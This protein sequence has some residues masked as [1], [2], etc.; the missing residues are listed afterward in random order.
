MVADSSMDVDMVDCCGE[1][2]V[3]CFWEGSAGCSGEVMVGCFWE[4]GAGCSG[5]VMVG[6]F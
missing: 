4:G 6:C 2:M 1:V 3:G 5:E